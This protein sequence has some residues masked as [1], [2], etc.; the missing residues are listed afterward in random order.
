M[1]PLAWLS[2]LLLIPLTGYVIYWYYTAS[3]VRSRTERNLEQAQRSLEKAAEGVTLSWDEV[4]VS[5]FPFSTFV[6]IINPAIER[7][8]PDRSQRLSIAYIEIRPQSYGMSRIRLETPS[9]FKAV[10]TYKGHAFVYEVTMTSLPEVLLR[11]PE[12]EMHLPLGRKNFFGEVR[13]TSPELLARLPQDVLHQMAIQLPPHFSLHIDYAGK[14]KLT[15]SYK[16]PKQMP[17]RW[18]PIDYMLAMDIDAFFNI[19]TRAVHHSKP[20]A[21]G[22]K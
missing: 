9:N 11:T 4:E 16:L 18:R 10:D 13:I 2:V 3:E 12:A 17:R 15:E 20:A 1:R 19:L 5:G 7:R 8:S 6:R 22:A 21:S 14:A